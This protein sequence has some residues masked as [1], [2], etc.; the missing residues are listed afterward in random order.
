MTTVHI[1]SRG[2]KQMEAKLGKL[3]NPHSTLNSIISMLLLGRHLKE[4]T[5]HVWTTG[6]GPAKG[7]TT[8]PKRK[9]G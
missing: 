4:R 6:S 9:P 1:F 7:P 3:K 8:L 2:L 5:G